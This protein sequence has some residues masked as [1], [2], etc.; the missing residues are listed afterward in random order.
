MISGVTRI[1]TIDQQAPSCQSAW[2]ARK[3]LFLTALFCLAGCETPATPAKTDIQSGLP[4]VILVSIDGFRPDYLHHGETPVLDSLTDEGVFAPMRPSFPSITFPNHYTLVTGL[5]PDH[6]GVV[7]NTMTDP[8]IPGETFSVGHHTGVDDPRWWNN[9]TPAWVTAQ[10]HGLMSAS[11]FWPGS[12]VPILNTRPEIWYH[13]DH[14]I[15]PTERV[16][17][18]LSWFDRPAEKRPALSLLYFDGVDHHGHVDGPFAPETRQAIHEVDDALR[19]LIAGLKQRHV[20]ANLIIVS[21]HGMTALSPQR[22]ISLGALAP[23]QAMNVVTAGPYA[24]INPVPGHERELARALSAPHEHVTCWP[25]T[26][27]PP[28]LHYGTNPRVP[29]WLCLAENGWTLAR[30]AHDHISKGGHGYDNQAPDMLATFIAAGPAFVPHKTLPTI[31]NVDVY[32]LVM[33]LL[34]LLPENNDGTL[35]PLQSGLRDSYRAIQ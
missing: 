34:G 25:K 27:I 30:D 22:V 7:G 10:M 17:T 4:P 6:H 15:T 19:V 18:V 20:Q 11:V 12:D 35:T 31:D 8:D 16:G 21:D 23:A 24:G 13:F 33:M 29:A 1:I 3:S 5:R 14:K 32:P 9:G 2:M 28:R 26:Q